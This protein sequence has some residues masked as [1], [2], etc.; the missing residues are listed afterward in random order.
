MIAG[1]QLDDRASLTAGDSDAAAIALCGLTQLAHVELFQAHRKLCRPEGRIRAGHRRRPSTPP[2]KRHGRFG[3]I[4]QGTSGHA[5][6][7]PN[8]EAAQRLTCS[9][10]LIDQPRPGE[11]RS[12]RRLDRNRVAARAGLRGQTLPDCLA[13]A[14]WRLSCFLHAHILNVAAHPAAHPAQEAIHRR[15]ERKPKAAVR[16]PRRAR[17]R[18]QRSGEGL[19]ERMFQRQSIRWNRRIMKM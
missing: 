10:D 6:C 15:L 7:G 16:E 1:D 19:D 17:K 9:L 18:I 14:E 11:G 12:P 3:T 13:A 8:T 2:E 4:R 5:I